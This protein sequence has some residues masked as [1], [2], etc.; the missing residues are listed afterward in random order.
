MQQ[1]IKCSK[2]FKFE[3]FWYAFERVVVGIAADVVV[4]TIVIVVLHPALDLSLSRDANHLLSSQRRA[5]S[6][7][8]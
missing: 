8:F 4:A 2:W 1:L 7:H 3:S 5:R 6:L